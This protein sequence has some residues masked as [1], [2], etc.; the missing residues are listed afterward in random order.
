MEIKQVYQFFPERLRE[1]WN[2]YQ[3][4]WEELQEI[5]IRVNQPVIVKMQGQEVLTEMV[6][7]EKDMDDIFRY[8]CHDSVYAYEIERCN[9]YLS[10]PGG[11][12]VG[13]TGEL[14]YVETTGYFAK[15]I[16]YMNIRIAHEKKGIAEN[17]M[18][19]LRDDKEPYNT[20]LIS[21]PGIGKTTL[22]RD[23]VRRFS[24]HGYTVGVIDERG[25]IAGAFRGC[26][27]LDCGMRTDVMTGG[28]KKQGVQILIRTFSPQIIAMD[29]I[30]TKGDAD[31]ICYAGVSGCK[32][33]ATVHGKSLQDIRSKDE[34]QILMR[35]KTFQRLVILSNDEG[36]MR[37]VEIL[38]GDGEVICG[39]ICLQAC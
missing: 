34:L 5:R 27:G 14:S 22:L 8:L 9:G 16:R 38:D 30:G 39:R 28:E 29:E 32:V 10:L 37:Y 4:Q 1:S 35:Q 17:V 15:Y 11:H 7:T 24:G 26:A 6:Y 23:I 2:R 21:P 36:G 19:Y 3:I 31:A 20:L 25:E 18:N 13:I 33:L 12:R